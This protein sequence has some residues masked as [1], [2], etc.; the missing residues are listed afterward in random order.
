MGKPSHYDSPLSYELTATVANG[1]TDSDATDLQGHTLCGVFLAS[2]FDGTTLGF[3][4]SDSLAGTYV[5]MHDG[6]SDV[7]KTVAAS[8]YVALNPSDFAGVR[9]LKFVAG[10]QT[11][12]TVITLATRP[13]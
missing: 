6:S 10:S 12:A 8:R 9:F 7:S 2:T 4:V 5:V 13:V 3:K 1:A 11:G